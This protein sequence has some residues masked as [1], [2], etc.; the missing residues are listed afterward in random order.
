MY[1]RDEAKQLKER[2]WTSFGQF[3]TL[4][5]SEE[6]LKI[7]WINYK[8]GIKH[9]FFRMEADN[10]TAR[11]FIEISHP[12]EGIRALMYEQFHSYKTVLEGELEEK[13]IWLPTVDNDFGKSSAQI[14]CTFEERISIFNQNDWPTLISF[15][16]P[17][18]IALDRFWS[19]AKY[20]FEIF[21]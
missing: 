5:P 18:I 14:I 12:D 10:K 4:V 15:F 3:M 8:T 17:R 11:I 20:A 13:W 16:K 6:G 7:N 1:S 21:K 19:N 9:L 2:F